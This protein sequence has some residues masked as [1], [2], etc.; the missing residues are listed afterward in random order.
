MEIVWSEDGCLDLLLNNANVAPHVCND[1][2]KA[3]KEN[4]EAV[5]GTNLTR[6]IRQSTSRGECY[7]SKEGLA[8]RRNLMPA[9]WHRTALMCS[10]SD[11]A[12]LKPMWSRQGSRSR[13]GSRRRPASAGSAGLARRHG[14]SRASHRGRQ[15]PLLRRPSHRRGRRLSPTQPLGKRIPHSGARC[16]TGQLRV[17]SKTAENEPLQEPASLGTAVSLTNRFVLGNIMVGGCGSFVQD[18]ETCQ[19]VELDFG[20]PKNVWGPNGAGHRD[21]TRIASKRSCS[22]GCAPRSSGETSSTQGTPQESVRNRPHASVQ[23]CIRAR[24]QAFATA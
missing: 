2:L 5:P 12:S 24:S 19:G 21:S 4:F 20:N 7:L 1:L 17:L 16:E 8:W 10:R 13:G 23:A 6:R 14:A 22:L 15:S 11:R 9:G 18:E 3:S